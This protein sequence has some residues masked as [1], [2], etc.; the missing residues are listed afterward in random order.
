M[1]TLGSLNIGDYVYDPRTYSIYLNGKQGD[2][3]GNLRASNC[4]KWRIIG[5]NQDGNN[6]VTLCADNTWDLNVGV[7]FD[8]AETTNPNTNRAEHGNSRYKLSNV[9][10]WLNSDAASN[11]CVSKHNYDAISKENSSP[12]LQY[13]FSS[14]LKNALTTFTKTVAIPTVDGGGTETV[15]AKVHLLSAKEVTG[16]DSVPNEGTQYQYYH[17]KMEE[18]TS[19]GRGD[20]DCGG[21]MRT[22]YYD[23]NTNSDC[24]VYSD[25]RYNYYNGVRYESHYCGGNIAAGGRC[26]II[27]LPSNTLVST[28]KYKQY[29]TS[30]S[31]SDYSMLNAML[32]MPLI[33]DIDNTGGIVAPNFTRTVKYRIYDENYTISSFK[34]CLDNVENVV[35]SSTN[36]T[37]GQEYSYTIDG[38]GYA[39]DESHKYYFIVTNSNGD[40]VQ[41]SI[42]ITRYNALPSIQIYDERTE[43]WGTGYYDYNTNYSK[44]KTFRLKIA[45]ADNEGQNIYVY[46]YKGSQVYDNIGT[47]TQDQ[48]IEYTL[49]DEVWKTFPDNYSTTVRIYASTI[50]DTSFAGYSQYGNEVEFAIKKVTPAP[51]VIVDS[52]DIGQKSKAF[53]VSYTPNTDSLQSLTNVSTYLDSGDNLIQSINNPTAGSQLSIAITKA[54][55]ASLSLG[56]H[57]LIF[58]VTDDLSQIGTTEVTFTKYNDAPNVIMES[59]L[60]NKNL[61]FDVSFSIQDEEEDIASVSMYIDS[62][63]STPIK[64]WSNVQTGSNLTQTI[65][66]EV[67]YG[68]SLGNHNIYV[69]AED[70]YGSTTATASFTRYNDAPVVTASQDTTIHYDD[71]DVTYQVTDTEND[72]VNLVFKVSDTTIATVTNVN[73]GE[74]LTQTIDI[75]DWEYGQKT[76]NIIATDSQG[77]TSTTSLDFTISTVPVITA[78]DIGNKAE[79]FSTTIKVDDEDGD[80]L[81]VI[82]MLNDVE[83]LNQENAPHNTPIQITIGNV[84]FNHIQYGI[85]TINISL[86]DVNGNTVMKD[87]TFNK[88]SV[89]TL[90][91]NT[92]IPQEIENELDIEVEYSNA[93][94]SE[95]SVKAYIDGREIPQ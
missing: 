64:V 59:T 93:D 15:S 38:T 95:V 45:D 8:A 74:L 77:Q 42:T 62:T 27:V 10:Q 53:E 48:E 6:T 80:A 26:P 12:A 29:A 82:A 44:P 91:V 30:T 57:K 25:I 51:Y 37:K 90:T 61:G 92:P 84:L 46:S 86:S 50:S 47:Y 28:D 63:T 66:K 9:L 88:C 1:A 35:Y 34:I 81:H 14:K 40:T 54:M 67:L 56:S 70:E 76:L 36:I 83:L 19:S 31:N 65:S 85:H 68:L 18:I 94:G 89:P 39:L 71:F 16:I 58:T 75:S 55:L 72:D 13:S 3:Q 33:I 22:P 24:K 4:I 49:S 69:V 87:I 7:L 11:W 78:D 73:K 32:T 17:D 43:K 52:A 2:S 20:F 21:L 41:E 60:G 23:G 5:K 79:S